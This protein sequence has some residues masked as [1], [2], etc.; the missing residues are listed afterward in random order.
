[1]IALGQF[2]VSEERRQYFDFTSSIGYLGYTY[3]VRKRERFN[4]YMQFTKPFEAKVW[5]YL[6]A[7][8]VFA[9]AYIYVIESWNPFS[10]E[11]PPDNRFTMRESVWYSYLTMSQAGAPFGARRLPT[12]VFSVFYWFFA[13]V[14]VGCYTGNLASFLTRTTFQ[15]PLFDI[16]NLE[17]SEF[18]YGMLDGSS[19]IDH[20]QDNYRHL[21][22]TAVREN[23]GFVDSYEQG[24]ERVMSEN[25]VLFGTST[26]LTWHTSEF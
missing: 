3:V 1:M 15:R 17:A 21:N 5:V 23:N 20:L 18:K 9:A 22:L 2:S 26:V 10:E 4:F 14:V 25:Y 8:M 16:Y 24:I 7:T 19:V 13:L 12:Q 6:C 11:V